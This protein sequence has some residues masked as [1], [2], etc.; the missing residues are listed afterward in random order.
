MRASQDVSASFTSEGWKV[1]DADIQNSKRF[2]QGEPWVLGSTTSTD[3]SA[4]DLMQNLRTLYDKDY[5]KQWRGF[6]YATRV[7]P[8]N[9]DPD[10]ASKLMKLSSNSDRKSTRLNSSHMS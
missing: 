6:L 10:A 9:N 7:L 4:A 5:I 1:M 3:L 8:Y 2:L